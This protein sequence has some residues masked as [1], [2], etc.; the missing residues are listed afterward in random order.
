MRFAWVPFLAFAGPALAADPAEVEFFEKK[1]R[2]VFV[3]H[4]GECHGAKKQSAGMRLDTIA[5][6]KKGTDDGPVVAAGKPDESRLVKAI[7]REGDNP[8]PPKE[9]LGDDAVAAIA[10]WVK[11]GAVLPDESATTKASGKDHWAFQKVVDPPVPSVPGATTPIDAFVRAKLTIAKLPSA[12]KADKRMLLRRAHYDLVGLP[13]TAE[14][15]DAF[16]KDTSPNAFEKA[17]D[18]LLESPHFGERWARHWMDVAR[19]SDTKG[20]VF[21]EDRSYPYA[22]TYRDYLIR[23]FNEDRPFNQMILEQVAADRLPPSEDKRELAALGFLTL[24]RRF[25]NN[26]HD[27]IDDRIDV[28]TRGFMGL[29]VGC[30]RCHDHKFDPIPIADYYSLYGVFAGTV[31]PKDPPLI[32]TAVERANAKVFDAE[33]KRMEKAAADFQAHM[34]AEALE[35]FRTPKSVGTY[36][37]AARDL[38]GKSGRDVDV[39]L[40]KNGLDVRI[41]ERWRTYLDAPHRKADPTFLAWFAVVDLPAEGFA[42]KANAAIEALPKGNVTVRE[43]LLAAEPESIRQVAALYGELIGGNVDQEFTLVLTGPGGVT[44]LEPMDADKL[45]PIAVKKEFRKLRNSADEFRATSPLSPPRAMAVQDASA[46]TQTVVFLRGNPQNKGPKVP[47]QFPSVLAGPDRKPFTGT[48]GRLDLA[49]AIA[50]PDNPLTARVYVNR[51]WGHLFGFGLVRTPSDF[52]TRSDPPTHPEL[53]DWLA[54]R[55]VQDG[56]ST[57]KLIKR[58]VLSDTYQQSSVAPADVYR[59]DPEN[60]ILAHQTRKRLEFEPLRDSLLIVA[61][62]LDTTV[63]GKSVDL[64][65][66]SASTRRAVYGYIDRQNLHGTFRA[67]DLATPDQH[68]PQRFQTTVPQQALYL[69]NSQ[70]VAEQAKA[71]AARAQVT[72]TKDDAGK[73]SAVYRLVLGRNPTTEETSLAVEFVKDGSTAVGKLGP[74]EQLAQVLL[75]S[76]E[77]AVV[78]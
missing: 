48:S 12:P 69:M 71:V 52:G 10:E 60:R 61:G 11:R 42:A 51:V 49:N 77:F 16:E 35:P 63:Y 19:Y 22:F 6:I 9:K 57:K 31:E 34:Y 73:A 64:F 59:L 58:I 53:L 27:I 20:Y 14:E 74:W 29:T 65:K 46:P 62:R 41:L 38:R 44:N 18:R 33:V 56:W 36:L 39:Y 23:S 5:G 68:A 37:L 3:E 1:V 30:A 43:T 55:F 78:D 13:P 15:F 8:M 26:Q 24:G 75:L 32:G 40:V 50:S 4:C 7:R 25:L 76:N 67:F 70:F 66:D 47:R 54:A 2:P 28:V 72:E 21:T 45:V 17:V